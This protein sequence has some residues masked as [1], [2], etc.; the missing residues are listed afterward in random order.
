M[1]GRASRAVEP[2]SPAP[3]AASLATLPCWVGSGFTVVLN[4]CRFVAVWLLGWVLRQLA[5]NP[6]YQID[7]L[8]LLR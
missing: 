6:R 3:P 7:Q 4:G 8:N 5:A 1:P 2:G